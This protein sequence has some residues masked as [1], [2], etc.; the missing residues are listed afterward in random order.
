MASLTQRR[1]EKAKHILDKYHKQ[2][3][4]TGQYS[5]SAFEKELRDC[6]G[7]GYQELKAVIIDL[8]KK[9]TYRYLAARYMESGCPGVVMEF[10]R[11]LAEMYGIKSYD[12][13]PDREEKRKAFWQ[14]MNAPDAIDREV[15]TAEELLASL[16][17]IRQDARGQELADVKKKI[18]E[19]NATL[20]RLWKRQD[21]LE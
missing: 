8:S 4:E 1:F 6:W 16:E 20:R 17:R 7:I 14:T 18:A 10:K 3:H 11:T 5:T 15:E 21:S 19:C 9:E 13:S 2:L 12:H